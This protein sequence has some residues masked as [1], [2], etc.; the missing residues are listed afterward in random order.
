MNLSRAYLARQARPR[1][2]CRRAGT[3][4]RSGSSTALALIGADDRRG[5]VRSSGPAPVVQPRGQSVRRTGDV[6][7]CSMAGPCSWRSSLIRIEPRS[8]C[9]ATGARRSREDP[10]QGRAAARGA[11]RTARMQGCPSS[12]ALPSEDEVIGLV[13]VVARRARGSGVEICA[14][15]QKVDREHGPTSTAGSR[16]Y[17]GN[18]SRARSASVRGIAKKR[19]AQQMQNRGSGRGSASRRDACGASSRCR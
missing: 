3:A 4:S 2:G 10:P 5:R 17:G 9:A 7:G 13:R 18:G 11:D 16:V 14:E 15:G 8:S 19:L 6:T 12:C 1:S